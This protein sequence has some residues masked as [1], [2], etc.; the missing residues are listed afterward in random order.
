VSKLK[1]EFKSKVL[2]LYGPPGV[3]KTSIVKSIAKCLN[4][5]YARVSLGGEYDTAVVKGHRRTYIGAYPGKIWDSIYRSKVENPV[6]LLDEIDK[7]VTRSGGSSLQ[8][9]VMEVLD[10]IQ[11]HRFKDDFMDVEIDL[12]RVLFVCTANTLDTIF[13]P[14]LDRLERIEVAGYTTH[15]KEA[16]FSRYIVNQAKDENGLTGEL[17]ESVNFTPEA[18]KAL[19]E[20]YCK[21]AGVRNLVRKTNQIFQKMAFKY[22]KG[23]DFDRKIVPDSLREYLG[24]PL[25]HEARLFKGSPPAGVMIGL[26]YNNYGGSIMYIECVNQGKH[27]SQGEGKEGDFKQGSLLVTG[28]IHDVMKESVQLAYTYAKFVC[29][30]LFSNYY[31]EENDVHINFPEIEIGKDGPSA[32]AAITSAFISLALQKPMIREIGMTGEITLSG[33]INPIGGVKEKTMG[34][35]REGVFSLIFPEDNRKDVE[36]LEPEIKEGMTFYFATH[37]F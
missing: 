26:A 3:G 34:A 36:E 31:L 30:S 29:S 10:P 5:P 15:E 17:A 2:L 25:F 32:G 19:I 6:I 16:I 18:V 4:R 35:K 20:R 28:N 1:G 11:N 24:L 13:P 27:K 33:R 37:Y 8:D 21:E 23:L 14:L 9:A 12:S 7:I 22:V